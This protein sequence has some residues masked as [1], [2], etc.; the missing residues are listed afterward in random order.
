MS[1]LNL[2][3]YVDS[4][5]DFIVIRVKML[6]KGLPGSQRATFRGNTTI[7]GY[8][9]GGQGGYSSA[10]R[11]S[12]DHFKWEVCPLQSFCRAGLWKEAA[13]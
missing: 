8:W 2:F 4:V 9:P 10:W 6:F 5:E 1:Q 3:F 12:E 13:L 11:P 7:S